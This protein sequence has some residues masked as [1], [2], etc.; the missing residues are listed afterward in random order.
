[1]QNYGIHNYAITPFHNDGQVGT[2]AGHRQRPR[3][4]RRVRSGGRC[5]YTDDD[6]RR[7][8]SSNLLK[9]AAIRA[10][11]AG[12]NLPRGDALHL[13]SDQSP[14]L[15][16]SMV[17]ILRRGQPPRR[18]PAQ[19][20]KISEL[21]IAA[22]RPGHRY[23]SAELVQNPSENPPSR[24]PGSAPVISQSRLQRWALKC[25]AIPCHTRLQS[26]PK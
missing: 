26:R 25:H 13:S 16:N 7:T 20:L 3:Q 19:R 5:R 15:G 17:N 24:W 9:K 11:P 4:G 14:G 22:R 12:S 10:N 8:T 1:M 23:P 21:L 18:V 6:R 2:A